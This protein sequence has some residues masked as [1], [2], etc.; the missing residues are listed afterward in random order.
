MKAS[1]QTKA[2]LALLAGD[3]VFLTTS[4]ALGTY[5]TRGRGVVLL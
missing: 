1:L 5:L 4:L 2:S 3:L